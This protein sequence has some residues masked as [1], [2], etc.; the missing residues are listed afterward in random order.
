[1]KYTD[2]EFQGN[3]RVTVS[4]KEVRVWVCNSVGQCVF[5]FKANGKV[6]RSTRH[7]PFDVIVG[8]EKKGD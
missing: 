7:E 1:M 2:D 8:Q 4:P 6:T 3:I 5:R